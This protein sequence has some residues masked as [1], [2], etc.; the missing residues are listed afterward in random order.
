MCSTWFEE[1]RFTTII[2]DP[3]KKKRKMKRKKKVN[4]HQIT[5]TFSRKRESHIVKL[6]GFKES[7]HTND[8]QNTK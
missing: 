1:T 3:E 5:P 7:A 2:D 4:L 6:K 8:S